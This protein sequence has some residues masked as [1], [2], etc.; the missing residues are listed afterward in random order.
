MAMTICKLREVREH[1]LYLA[2]LIELVVGKA[3]DA[4]E[5]DQVSA[6]YPIYGLPKETGAVRRRSMDLTRLLAELRSSD[7]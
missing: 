2:A 4:A 3:E 7:R 1:C 5:G 6:T